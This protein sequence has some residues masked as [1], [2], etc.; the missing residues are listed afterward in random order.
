MLIVQICEAKL[1]RVTEA[2]TPQLGIEYGDYYLSSTQ[3]P[4]PQ[5]PEMGQ[6]LIDRLG[7][8]LYQS[9]V[10]TT[11]SEATRTDCTTINKNVE[12]NE[13]KGASTI[14]YLNRI[15]IIILTTTHTPQC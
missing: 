1:I 10:I 3:S 4:L 14:T 2:I 9:I 7:Y 6:L 11:A 5:Q 12:I 15:K 13:N 8:Y